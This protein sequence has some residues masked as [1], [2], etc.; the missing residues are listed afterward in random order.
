MLIIR[1]EIWD[2]TLSPSCPPISSSE[3]N[4]LDMLDIIIPLYN[5]IWKWD[6]SFDTTLK[7]LVPTGVPI[8]FTWHFAYDR[9]QTKQ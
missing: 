4:D 1:T 9:K 5:C 6:N 7:N 3:D 8:C 2:V